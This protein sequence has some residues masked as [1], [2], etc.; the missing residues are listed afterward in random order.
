[1]KRY[2]AKCGVEYK[3]RS[4]GFDSGFCFECKPGFF[5]LPA[6]LRA[7]SAAT[8]RL[9][10]S[11]ACLHVFLLLIL[12]VLMDGGAFSIPGSLYCLTVL[13]YLAFRITLSEWKGYPILS[14]LQAVG[15]FILPVY[16]LPFFLFVFYIVQRTKYGAG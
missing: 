1:M 2:C 12:S 3:L 13:L 5:S 16:G 15:L 9:W 6:W 8:R 11:S 4:F 7:S 10:H 14:K